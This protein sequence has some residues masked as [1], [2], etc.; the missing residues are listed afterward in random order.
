MKLHW[1][2]SSP[3]VRKVMVCAHALGIDDRIACERSP[4]GP[5]RLNDAVMADNPLNKIPTLITEQGMALYDSRAIC[6]YLDDL[7]G[8]AILFP[9]AGPERWQALAWQCL[10]DGLIDVAVLRRDEYYRG[11]GH[12]SPAHY[13]AFKTKMAAA[14][15]AMEAAVPALERGGLTIGTI[16][17][18]VAL[19]Y[20]DFRPPGEEWRDGRLA[21]AN[22][23][24]EFARQ[25]AMLAAP[26]P[27]E[28][29]APKQFP[30]YKI[31]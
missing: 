13:H 28:G 31:E 29:G 10:A 9:A 7:A 5:A 3:F 30:F 24:A 21:L 18:G 17:I 16:S 19:A 1:S 25:P 14:L 2:P 27:D 8:G 22:W 11:E 26:F 23:E 20:L 4:V 6:E 12:R 15:D